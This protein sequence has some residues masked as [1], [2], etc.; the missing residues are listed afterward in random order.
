MIVLATRIARKGGYH[1]LEKH[2]LDK[3]EENE[4]VQILAGDRGVF[5][6]AQALADSK[7]CKYAL[8]HLSI[9]PERKMSARQ[10]AQFVRSIDLEFGIGDQRP[11]LVV[12]HEKGGRVHFHV[13]ISEVDPATGRVLDSRHDYARLE[14]LAREYEAANDE[15]LQLSRSDRA[16]EK[17]E[18]FSSKARHKAERVAGGFDR[19]RLKLATAK[20]APELE[21]ELELQGLSIVPGDKGLILVTADGEFVAAAH[22]AAG[23]M[24]NQFE[25]FWEAYHYER[26]R[27]YPKGNAS[28]HSP[29]FESRSRNRGKRLSRNRQTQ[30][31]PDIHLAISEATNRPAPKPFGSRRPDYATLARRRAHRAVFEQSLK[32]IDL[33]ELLRLAEA[34]AT[35]LMMIVLGPRAQLTARIHRARNGTPPAA[36]G[37]KSIGP[38]QG[39]SY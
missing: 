1:R 28:G 35:A 6:D 14:R 36:N 25:E 38:M 19:T 34:L 26:T 2:L 24:K 30:L 39:P 15:R 37:N 23:L 32:V 31:A 21:R 17:V 22:R 11:R 5:A 27:T 8:R 18:G 12:L 10:L 3:P 16:I 29:H 13:A 20:G 7:K 9:S 4:R 33:D